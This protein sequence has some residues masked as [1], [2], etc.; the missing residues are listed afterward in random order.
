MMSLFLKS[1]QTYIDFIR[2]FGT[3]NAVF[4]ATG[5]SEICI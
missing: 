4:L 1:K 3:Y 2:L 5:G